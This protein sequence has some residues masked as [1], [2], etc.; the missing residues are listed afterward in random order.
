MGCKS[1]KKKKKKKRYERL[2]KERG[3]AYFGEQK[4]TLNVEKILLTRYRY[5][6]FFRE[7]KIPFIC[8][9]TNYYIES[10][11]WKILIDEDTPLLLHKKRKLEPAE[12]RDQP[13]TDRVATD[14]IDIDHVDF[15][16][17][18]ETLATDLLYKKLKVSKIIEPNDFKEISK[19]RIST[20]V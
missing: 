19:L 12:V 17:D 18:D 1:K 4:F 10:L 11:L 14:D 20:D 7:G 15:E 16:K 5:P 8:G 3:G 9:G 13:P 2:N 6:S